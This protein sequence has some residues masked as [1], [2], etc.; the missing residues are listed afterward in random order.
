MSLLLGWAPAIEIFSY[1]SSVSSRE[2]IGFNLIKSFM[3][4]V[5]DGVSWIVWAS[6]VEE[7]PKLSS[8]VTFWATTTTSSTVSAELSR[9]DSLAVSLQPN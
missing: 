7:Y 6:I 5:T 3:S 1:P 8:D 9:K 2:T 4:L